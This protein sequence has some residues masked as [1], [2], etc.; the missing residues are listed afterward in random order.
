MKILKTWRI[1][2]T[3]ATALAFS[4]ADAFAGPIGALIGVIG[5][6]AQGASIGTALLGAALSIGMNLIMAAMQPKEKVRGLKEKL[7]SGGD[8]PISFV[9]GEYATAGKLVYVNQGGNKN[10]NMLTLVIS[11]S[12]LPITAF[13][14]KI[15]I[16]GEECTVDTE[17]TTNASGGGDGFDNDAPG[18]G[19]FRVVEYD[20]R[21][22]DDLG[23]QYCW[24]KFYDGTQTAADPYLVSKFGDDEDKP[25]TSAMVGRGCAYVIAVCRYS[26]KGVWSGVPE[27]KFPVKG[28]KL[29]DRTKDSTAGGSGP[30]R[31]DDPSTWAY[32]DNPKVMI[33]NILRGIH[34]NGGWIWG[35]QGVRDYHLPASYWIAAI[36]HC[37]ETVTKANGQ[38]VKRYTA[39]CEVHV[40][41]PPIDVIKELD[42]CCAGTTAEYGGL[43]KT[44]AGPPGSAILSITDKDIIV[45]EDQQDDLIKPLQDTY[46]GARA[47]Y[48]SP[49]EGWVMKDAPPRD[50][51]DLKAEDGGYELI[52]DLQFPFVTEGNQVQRL[53]RLMVKESRKQRTHVLQLPPEVMIAE[54]N[55]VISWAS[56]R[57][58]YVNKKFTVETF[59]DLQ[60]CNQLMMLRECD[61]DDYDW[62]T[63]YE[64]EEIVGPL[65]PVKPAPLELDFS[66]YADTVDAP[67]GKKDK[68]AIRVEWDWG[69][70]DLDLN[71]I[72][73][74]VRRQG[75]TKV[76]ARG[77]F[78]DPESGQGLITS[79][80][81]RFGKTYEVRFYPQPERLY[82]KSSWTAWKTV[83]LVVASTP[84]GLALTPSS[85]LGDDGKLDFFVEAE[86]NDVDFEHNGYGVRIKIDGK[87]TYKRTDENSYKFAVPSGKTVTVAVRTRAADGGTHSDWSS[88]VSITVTKKSTAPTTPTGFTATGRHRR[89]VIHADDHP[90]KDFKRWCVYYG[91]TNNFTA[92]TK[93]KRSRSNKIIVDN[94]SPNTDYYFWITAEDK[95]GNESA[96]WPSSNTAGVHAKTRQIDD[97]DTNDDVLAAP[98]GLTLSKVQ[99]TDEDGTVR[100]FIKMSCTPPAWATEKTTYVFGVT[101]SGG[102]ED[103]IKR[104]DPKA[105]YLV[106]ETGVS[107]SV[108]VRAVKGVGSKSSWSSAV[109]IT[110]GKKTDLP[111]T[112]T[113]VVALSKAK[114]VRIKWNEPTDKDFKRA[115]VYRNTTNNAGTASVV[116]RSDADYYRDDDDLVNGATYYYWVAFVNKSG[117]EGAKS[118]VASV[119]YRGVT[120]ADIEDESIPEAKLA[121]EAIAAPTGLTLQ[122]RPFDVDGDGSVDNAFKVTFSAPGSAGPKWSYV[123]EISENGEIIDKPKIDEPYH[124]FKV[125]YGK[126]YSVRA[127][128]KNGAGSKSAW[129]S[130]VSLTAGKKSSAPSGVSGA[131]SLAISGGFMVF[132]TAP[133]DPDYSHTEVAFRNSSGTPSASDIVAAAKV[134]SITIFRPSVVTQYIYVRHVNTSGVATAW[135]QAGFPTPAGLMTSEQISLYAVTETDNFF[136]GGTSS[137][138]LVNMTGLPTDGY[139]QL[140]VAACRNGS[141]SSIST[142][143]SLGSRSWNADIGAGQVQTFYSMEDSAASSRQF[144][145]TG[146]N[147]MT[148]VVASCIT[149]KR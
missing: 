46:N 123:L 143:I 147:S 34:Y 108:R 11:V 63:E 19:F 110:P 139:A 5:S 71:H 66:V 68:P 50:F 124:F 132:W 39:G 18:P 38:T 138:T 70:Q 148:G 127:R 101:P 2:L 92:T 126:T 103:R 54:T 102:E 44:W 6:I 117:N 12:E 133:T 57:N 49:K 87:T 114:A 21:D 16:N 28:I 43:W 35:G 24:L 36:N 53:M 111:S 141:S 107:H 130:A 90:D 145:Q 116:G 89:V 1:A 93:E 59:D 7:E 137:N 135:V 32:S 78:G 75:T 56:E 120:T 81:L 27:F 96:K 86:W 134:P 113:G 83:T 104:D 26:K 9:M 13:S 99:K 42:K 25:W 136:V 98:S 72:K 100:T 76:I 33:E 14:N 82:R 80:S 62:D 106:E 55:D 41:Q 149:F 10:N 73:Y 67:G 91:T 48:V 31:S 15:W 17:K 40:D 69:A 121:N 8:N 4:A 29:Y 37:N 20:K 79:S 47:T 112:P 52:A 105:R 77:R 115:K 61:P 74:R 122:Q 51:P 95:S 22:D 146:G 30:Q 60:N 131:S 144:T 128:S 119:T 140:L 129:T 109:T 45:S 58:G 94:L 125:K 84:T 65:T 85:D 23:H 118:S 142:Q 3:T 97:D 64:L 88:E